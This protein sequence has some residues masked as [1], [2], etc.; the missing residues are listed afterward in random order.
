ISYNTGNVGIGVTS[1]TNAALEILGNLS[2]SG[3]G[4][5]NSIISTGV[6]NL[7]STTISGT[8]SITGLA[9]T[10]SLQI[11]GLSNGVLSV[12]GLGNVVTTSG[13]FSQWV[14]STGGSNISYNGGGVSIGTTT[15]AGGAKLKVQGDGSMGG[16][17]ISTQYFNNAVSTNSSGAYVGLAT[18]T[19][20]VPAG[21][22]R[23]M[24]TVYAG[25]Q[26]ASTGTVR[27]RVID[28]TPTNVN[29]SAVTIAFGGLNVSPEM[30]LNFGGL[31]SGW[32]TIVVEGQAGAGDVLN[33][34][35]YTIA[36]K[37]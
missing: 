28:S 26:V 4:Y 32:V 37:D 13:T 18:V 8:A 3:I 19:G 9:A 10:Q 23:L 14:T 17:V 33:V 16:M 36:I 21:T 15:L 2:A 30:V 27:F 20:Y 11:N 5:L 24:A 22:N 34:I 12:D 35:S 1:P 29:S 25:S 6:A 31:N 7:G